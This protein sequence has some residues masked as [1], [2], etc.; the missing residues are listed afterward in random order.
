GILPPSSSRQRWRS[1]QT[2]L[3]CGLPL[4]ERSLSAGQLS[5]LAESCPQ[6][7][8]FVPQR[9]PFVECVLREPT[10]SFLD[11]AGASSFG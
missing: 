10:A 4:W 11:L 5:Q 2:G 3:R 7:M 9:S 8:F 1:S 6:A